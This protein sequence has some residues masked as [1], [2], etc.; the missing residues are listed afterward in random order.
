MRAGARAGPGRRTRRTA[1][2]RR[3]GEAAA[4][5]ARYADT[6]DPTP[7]PTAAGLLPTAA[8]GGASGPGRS[9]VIAAPGGPPPVIRSVREAARS[10]SVLGEVDVLVCGGGPA[11]TAAAIAAAREGART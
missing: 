9:G 11:G 4:I 6:F 8:N 7:G 3:A 1:M 10:L 2:D 5:E